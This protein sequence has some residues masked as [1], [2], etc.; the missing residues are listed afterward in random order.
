[1]NTLT[2]QR[3]ALRDWLCPTNT[4]GDEMYNTHD[5]KTTNELQWACSTIGPLHAS[6]EQTQQV[7]CYGCKRPLD[8]V[9]THKRSRLGTTFTVRAFYRHR[10]DMNSHACGS[11]ETMHHIAAKDAVVKYMAK[12][13]YYYVCKDCKT[14]VYLQIP[15]E[16][17]YVA[18]EE[19]PW[20]CPKGENYRLDVAV[21]N[22]DGTII[23]AIEV[24]ST[25][26]IGEKKSTA[27]SNAN[28]AWCEVTAKRVLDAVQDNTWTVQV[29]Q[30]GFDICCECVEKIRSDEF[31]RLDI[32][33]SAQLCRDATLKDRRKQI[34]I[35]TRKVW[36][37][38]NPIKLEPEDEKWMRIRARV[39]ANIVKEFA[40]TDTCTDEEAICT[41]V[42]ERLDN[43]SIILTFGKHRM[44]TIQEVA[45]IDWQYLLWLAGY[46]FGRL[47]VNCKPIPRKDGP[48]VN[49]ITTEIEQ[50]ARTL[51]KNK[52]IRCGDQILLSESWKRVCRDCYKWNCAVFS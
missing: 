1:M 16:S 34:I 9:K 26:G 8:R 35:Q 21:L 17:E 27:L 51:T 32:E 42:I 49:F 24:L 19:V 7:V 30:C 3:K 25:H 46:N 22:S 14:H 13:K 44:R 10:V 28:L 31:A 37:K 5:G 50:E 43:P 41:E 20:R 15:M 36:S 45:D 18:H 6:E 11:G 40:D 2:R 52:C 4:P 39:L 23:G 33:R 12:L 29:I 48:G 47:D 38:L